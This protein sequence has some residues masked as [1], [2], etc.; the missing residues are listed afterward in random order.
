MQRTVPSRRIRALITI[1]VVALLF[2][3]M[4]G[5]LHRIEHGGRL[6][7]AALA[8]AASTSVPTTLQTTQST[9]AL[10]HLFG[11]HDAS[12]CDL[13][14]QVTHGDALWAAAASVLPATFADA[15]AEVHTAWHLAA[16]AAGFLARGPPALS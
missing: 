9:G 12:S 2:A 3:Q 6:Q 15:P 10:K 14:D 8:M 13:Y 5:L 1:S 4:L 16:Q 11:H 7:I